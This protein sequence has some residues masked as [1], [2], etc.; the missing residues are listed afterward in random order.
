MG[1]ERIAILKYEVEEIQLS[2]RAMCAS[3]SS[4]HEVENLTARGVLK[5]H[6]FSRAVRVINSKGALAPGTWHE[7]PTHM[8]A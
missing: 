1:V 2:T 6:G 3:W 4:S 8:A 7:N 5:G